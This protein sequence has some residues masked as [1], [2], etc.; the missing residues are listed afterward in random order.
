MRKISARTRAALLSDT[1]M[2]SCCLCRESGGKIEWHH[3]LIY[4]GRQADAP[5]TILP[6][7]VECHAGADKTETKEKLDYIMLNAATAEDLAMYPKYSY[8]QRYSYLR[9]KYRGIV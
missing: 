7:C 8:Q 4:A 9:D 5:W 1:R 2:K 6:L 3:N